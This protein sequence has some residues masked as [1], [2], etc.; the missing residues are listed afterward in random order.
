MSYKQR[1]EKLFKI[2]FIFAALLVAMFLIGLALIIINHYFPNQVL[3]LMFQSISIGLPNI[4]NIILGSLI[5][6]II[7]VYSAVVTMDFKEQKDRDDLILNF[8]YELKELNEKI[9]RIPTEDIIQCT[10]WLHT[11]KNP[12]YPEY[13][14]FFVFRKELFSI[15]KPLLEKMLPIYSKFNFIEQQRKNLHLTLPSFDPDTPLIVSQLKAELNEFLPLIESEKQK[16][17]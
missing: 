10:T 2:P 5:A 13:G 7:G 16:I 8:Y 12:V 11:E 4:E 9:Q 6:S 15:E 1:R 17:Q 3:M 14:A